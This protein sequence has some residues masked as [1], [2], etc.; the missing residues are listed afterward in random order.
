MEFHGNISREI[1]KFVPLWIGAVVKLTPFR[2]Q[3][4]HCNQEEPH[5]YIGEKKGRHV[6]AR[7]SS[8]VRYCHHLWPGTYGYIIQNV[9]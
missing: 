4:S 2:Y 5:V 3:D 8:A 1:L 6:F 7:R 9:R